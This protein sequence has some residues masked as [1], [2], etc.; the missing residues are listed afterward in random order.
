MERA[1]G[2]VGDG[3]ELISGVVER[4]GAVVS[5]GDGL[6]VS[7]AVVGEGLDVFM[8][9]GDGLNLVLGVKGVGVAVAFAVDIMAIGVGGEGGGDASRWGE[10]AVGLADKFEG[11]IAESNGGGIVGNLVNSP[12]G[13]E[14]GSLPFLGGATVDV[15][16]A[17]GVG[18]S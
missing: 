10:G 17:N 8:G 1:S 9:I 16:L 12:S 6:K 2:G 5:I 13:G 4:E 11:G 14:N 18:T 15:E 7:V 3:G